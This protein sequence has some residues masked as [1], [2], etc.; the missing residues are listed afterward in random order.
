MDYYLDYIA[1]ILIILFLQ[2]K[3]CI[4]RVKGCCC[5]KTETIFFTVDRHNLYLTSTVSNTGNFINAIYVSVSTKKLSFFIVRLLP[6][7][8]LLKQ[9]AH[10]HMTKR[11][12][13][14]SSYSRMSED[15]F[16][17]LLRLSC[18]AKSYDKVEM[19]R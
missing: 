1:A 4:L 2:M 11:Y 19:L 6:T 14:G 7:S 18:T 3:K 8:R 10:I 16:L 12:Y 9:I 17:S 13:T 5:I 15:D